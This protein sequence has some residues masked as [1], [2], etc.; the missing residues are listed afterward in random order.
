MRRFLI[1]SGAV[2]L[3]GASLVGCSN[4]AEGA[5]Q[6]AATDTQA[7]KDTA[8]KAVVATDKAASNAAAATGKA[9]D[10]AAAATSK[11]ADNAAAATSK[12]A[13][14]VAAATGKAVDETTKTVGA[15]GKNA[16]DALTLTPKVKL[17]ITNDKELN[18]TKNTINIDTADNV[19]HVKGM[20]LTS[21]MKKRAGDI[22]EKTVKDAGS[23]DKVVN[24]LTVNPKGDSRG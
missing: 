13:D 22:A 14:H 24:E 10:N 1:L 6:D 2:V 17:A 5:K 8:D 7:A 3:L 23:N 19:V 21:E 9:L 4:T 20:V 12:A 18:N 15:A 16:G 11:A